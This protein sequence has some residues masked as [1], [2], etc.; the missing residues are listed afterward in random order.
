MKY[1]TRNC[2]NKPTYNLCNSEFKMYH[3]QRGKKNTKR[4]SKWTVK[5]STSWIRGH[6][7]ERLCQPLKSDY[8]NTDAEIL[9]KFITCFL[10]EFFLQVLTHTQNY[11]PKPLKLTWL[12]HPG[13]IRLLKHFSRFGHASFTMTGKAQKPVWRARAFLS[14]Y[15]K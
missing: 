5:T 4:D 14:Q 6:L 2:T 9:H 12:H 7:L 8:F 15:E 3:K 10:P 1:I 11:T 13:R